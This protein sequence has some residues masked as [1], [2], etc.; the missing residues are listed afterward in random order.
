MTGIVD[1]EKKLFNIPFGAVGSLYFKSDLPPELHGPLYMAG[2]PDEAG[3][4]ETYCIGPIADYMF[5][6][7]QR[8]KLELDRGPCMFFLNV[9]FGHASIEL[10]LLTGSDPI[11]YLLATAEKE[12]KWIEKFGKPT[13][14]DFP[15]NTVSPALN[16]PKIMWNSS[17]S[18]C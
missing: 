17:R 3:D 1:I 2:T 6:Y 8:A 5:W 10:I 14:S 4:S 12:V 13:E 7:G 11:N 16:P 9:K 15:H 18:T